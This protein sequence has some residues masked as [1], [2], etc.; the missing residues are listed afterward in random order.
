MAT[1]KRLILFKAISLDGVWV[2]GSHN[3]EP[4]GVD[5]IINKKGE[6]TEIITE[7]VCQFTGHLDAKKDKIF[8]GDKL[9][10]KNAKRGRKDLKVVLYEFNGFTSLTKLDKYVIDSNIYDEYLK[11]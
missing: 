8:E 5:F 7:T 11:Q 9:L 10:L 4:N 6:I 3:I 2:E 1:K